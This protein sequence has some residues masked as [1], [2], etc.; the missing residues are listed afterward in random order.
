MNNKKIKFIPVLGSYLFSL[1]ELSAESDT[2]LKLI[3]SCPSFNRHGHLHPQLKEV[4]EKYS[5]AYDDFMLHESIDEALSVLYVKWK[6]SG[7][8]IHPVFATAYTYGYQRE[9]ERRKTDLI[10]ITYNYPDD[11]TVAEMREHLVKA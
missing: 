8:D 9:K 1:Y 10:L 6:L 3:T 2:P 7:T 4:M 5:I 11:M